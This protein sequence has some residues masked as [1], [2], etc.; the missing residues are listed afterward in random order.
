MADILDI[1]DIEQPGASEIT[2]DSIIH[3]DKSKKKYV[4]TKAVRRPEGM[5]REVFALLFNDNELPPLLPTDT[6]TYLLSL[7]HYSYFYHHHHTQHSVI[8][9]DYVLKWRQYLFY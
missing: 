6:G 2:R 8:L 5:H 3:G 9:Y 1:L 4:T 7:I